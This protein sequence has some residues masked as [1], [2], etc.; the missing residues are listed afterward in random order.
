MESPL[1]VL[2][3]EASDDPP[4]PQQTLSFL[5]L[6]VEVLERIFYFLD[7]D[8]VYGAL[9]TCKELRDVI[10]SSKKV[11]ARQLHLLPG[12]NT[13]IATLTTAELLK[14]FRT[15]AAHSLC[16]ASLFCSTVRYDADH[17]YKLN[18]RLSMFYRE[19]GT[20]LV[21]FHG[22]RDLHTLN[23][24]HGVFDMGSKL[25][26][27]HLGLDVED[28]KLL[29]VSFSACQDILALYDRD[30]GSFH[31]PTA[32]AT[33]AR[34]AYSTRN[35]SALKCSKLVTFH[36]CSTTLRGSFYT[37]AVQDT[38]DIVH[39]ASFH[40]VG[41][42][43]SDL[44]YVAVSWQNGQ[45]PGLVRITVHHRHEDLIQRTNYDPCPRLM[46]IETTAMLIE[47]PRRTF[48]MRFIRYK[49]YLF[50]YV[51]ANPA[52]MCYS[53]IPYPPDQPLPV[54]DL[55]ATNTPI[56][57]IEKMNIDV[58]FFGH[59]WSR[60]VNAN[61]MCTASY[62]ALGINAISHETYIVR[63]VPLDGDQDSTVP[64]T[65]C[66]HNIDPE[67]RLLGI[68]RCHI[69]AKLDGFPPDAGTV[70]SLGPVWAVSP[71][72]RRIAI[73]SWTSIS[74]WVLDP[75][76]LAEQGLKCIPKIY[77]PGQIDD[78]GFVH[79]DPI[80]LPSR[81]VV[82]Q[83][84]FLSEDV[85]YGITDEGIICWDMS[86]SARGGSEIRHLPTDQYPFGAMCTSA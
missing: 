43:G 17:P 37:S 71:R 10:K 33:A 38:M 70:N 16:C 9:L 26:P 53:E 49:P 80:R 79:L 4:Q 27:T 62:L 75:M 58:P 67:F 39:P 3:L 35:S 74:V 20:L 11:L 86:A 40:P 32:Q 61:K 29:K 6:P 55:T 23:A 30:E 34:V 25:Q 46:I 68:R 24:R 5:D 1:K 78:L 21:S 28:V 85:F 7:P 66:Q 59:H 45:N 73:A 22:Q 18:C 8:T 50:H 48:N 82:Y 60:T 41:L 13:S 54:H 56:A 2:S 31:V 81:G 57:G 14:V 65:E 76:P 64:E 47:G 52:P 69:L 51:P 72:A 63:P 12:E 36:H 77:R 83:L 15:R 44:G 19:S 42:A 84:V